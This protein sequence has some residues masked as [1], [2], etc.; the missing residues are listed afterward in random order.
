MKKR[1][2]EHTLLLRRDFIEAM[3]DDPLQF[4]LL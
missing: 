4:I 3:G 2:F 1:Y